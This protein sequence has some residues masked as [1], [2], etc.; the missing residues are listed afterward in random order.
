MIEREKMA[1]WRSPRAT[2]TRHSA[3]STASPELLRRLARNAHATVLAEHTVQSR[4]RALLDLLLHL[5]AQETRGATPP[6][7]RSS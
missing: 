4:G 7:P 5:L 6:V 1:C 3:R 2:G